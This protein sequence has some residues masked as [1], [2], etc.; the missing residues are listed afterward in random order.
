MLE[1]RLTCG[2]RYVPTGSVAS[3][4]QVD[5]DVMTLLDRDDYMIG[6][7]AI[8]HGRFPHPRAWGCFPRVVGRLRR[9]TG[10]ALEP[11][12]HR[13]TQLPATRFGLDGRGVIARGA[14]ADLVLFDEAGIIDLATFEDP[15]MP[16]A[17]IP[18]V[19]VNGELAVERGELTGALAGRPVPEV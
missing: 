2:F 17:G 13:V 12:I 9:R 11:V 15:R 1:E 5:E 6:S 8:P 16:P 19:V 7:D 10:R 3:W 18:Y 14:F 4:Q